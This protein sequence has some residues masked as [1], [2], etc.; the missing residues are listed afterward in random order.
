MAQPMKSELSEKE[1]AQA[2]REKLEKMARGAH[3]QDSDDG[4]N[5]TKSDFLNKRKE[6]MQEKMSKRDQ[7]VEKELDHQSKR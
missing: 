3:D 1:K 4:G 7:A 2:K 5:L 6:K